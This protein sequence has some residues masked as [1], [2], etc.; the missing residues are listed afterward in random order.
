M[1]SSPAGTRLS[2]FARWESLLA[3]V[4]LA[5]LPVLPLAEIVS[6][7]ALSRGIPGSLPV[8][9]HL[10]LWIAFLGASIAARSDRLLAVSTASFLPVRYASSV[11]LLTTAVAARTCGWL[12]AA[13]YP[14]IDAMRDAGDQVAW[15]IPVWAA[16][17]V[18]PVALAVIGFRLILRASTSVPWRLAASL[19]MVAPVLFDLIPTDLRPAWVTPLCLLIA[20][21]AALGM[22]LFAAI[23][24]AALVLFWGDG[25]TVAAVPDELYKLSSQEFLPAIPMF[26][27]A[28]YLLAEGGAGNRLLRC[29]LAF[30]GWMPGGLAIVTTL[31]LAFFT[32][33]TGASGITILSLGGLL[34]PML[35]AARYPEKSS[36]GLVTVSGSIGLLL[37]PSLPVILYAIAA[38]VPIHKL[39]LATLGPGILLIAVVAAWGAR[40]GWRSGSPAQPFQWRE[41]ALAT[42]QAKWELLLPVV[43]LTSYFGGYAT[44]VDTSA[45]AAV[46]VF[47]IESFVHRGLRLKADLPRIAV[48]CVTLVGAFLVIVGVALSF[49]NY[50]VTAEVPMKLLDWVRA[51]IQSPVIFLL[52]LN[53]FLVLV[54]AVMDIYS[55][56]LVVVPL[57]I[58]LGAAYSIDPLHL[59]VIFLANMELGYLMPPMGENLFLAAFRFGRPLGAI[60]VATI[61]YLIIL[62]VTVMLI[63][64]L[65]SL[66]LSLTRIAK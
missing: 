50:L 15:G 5:A 40:E 38:H 25:I 4:V 26:S 29:F 27:I 53:L 43:I 10:T 46:Y 63:S 60:Y 51:H 32:P 61:P 14:L 55:A 6:R 19:G 34:L 9:Q 49:T 48:E 36:I 45:I 23:G 62:A 56:I 65:P 22:P 39:F 41:A 16:L 44:L 52:A 12:V 31:V 54:G 66:S 18:I 7:E 1:N 2:W 21:S 37:P 3:L 42:W 64:Y 58:P 8:L 13:S 11:R 47:V 24:G 57:I 35:T 20:I 30:L 59:G 17:V 28:G 33:L